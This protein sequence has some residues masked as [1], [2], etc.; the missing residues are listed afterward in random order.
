MDKLLERNLTIEKLNLSVR[1]YNCLKTANINTFSDLVFTTDKYLSNIKNMGVKSLEEINEVIDKL[2]SGEFDYE[3]VEND[4]VEIK[5]NKKLT[6]LDIIKDNDKVVSDISYIDKY[7]GFTNDLEIEELDLSVRS[8]NAIVKNGYKSTAQLINLKIK[9]FNSLRNL[10]VKSKQEIIERLKEVVIITYNEKSESNLA[11]YQDILNEIMDDFQLSLV[12]Y[13][14]A[15]LQKRL[16]L[17]IQTAM[18]GKGEIIKTEELLGDDEFLFS[19]YQ[20]EFLTSLIQNHIK[21]FIDDIKGQATLIDIS[22]SL[23]NHLLNS[24]LIDNILINMLKEKII[25]EKEGY[26]RRYYP[27]LTD[28]LENL[29]DKRESIVLINRLNGKTLEEIGNE[30]SVTRERVR[31][32]EKKAFKKIP[33]VREDDY[34]ESFEIYN[35]DEELFKCTWKESLFVY[36][37]L[38]S[39]Y[40]K[41]NVNI[42]EMLED[43][44]IPVKVRLRSENYI[45]KDYLSIGNSRIKKERQEILEYVIRIY[46]KDEVT[47]EELA[48]LYEMFLEDNKLVG[49]VNLQFTIRYFEAAVCRSK[50]VLWKFKRKLR[51]YDISEMTDEKIVESLN[52]NQLDNVEYSTLKLFNDYVEVMNEWDI[53]DEYE[54]HNLMKKVLGNSDLID[55]KFLRMPNIEFGKADRDIQVLELLLQTAPI[56]NA[57]LAKNYENE[58]GVK[59]ETV[60]A[61]YFKGIDEYCHNSIY[62]IDADTLVGDEFSIM[63]DK[64]DKDVYCIKDIKSIYI[65]CFPKGDSTLISPYNLK[66]LGFKI[67]SKLI[68]SD[69]Y[70]TLDDYFKNTILKDEIYDGNLLESHILTS[71]TYYSVIQQLKERFEIVEFLPNIFINIKRLVNKGI[72]KENLID[73]SNYV[74]DFVGDEI[75]TIKYLKNRGMEHSLDELGFDEWFYSSLIR[76][77]SRFKF[78]RVSGNVMFRKGN[79]IVSINNLI[80]QI[81]SEYRKIDIYDLIEV[82]NKEYGIKI[83]KY[84]ISNAAKEKELYYDTIMEKIYIDYDEYFE[85]V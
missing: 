17:N 60:L 45:F 68:Y 20:D 74:D 44:N 59:A 2:R 80:E 19:I 50:K 77:D 34:K 31:Q 55:I 69:K 51:Y 7:R 38:I 21:K 61:N 14:I 39:K 64:L 52:L 65:R 25:E 26:Y 67:T 66:R 12:E 82:I 63:K 29:N 33:R 43:V 5:L 1:T 8:Y 49:I 73:F 6:I 78:R 76:I 27:N 22:K 83:E 40:E 16:L 35:W 72:Y 56:L 3:L 41:G 81:V 62:S 4:Y 79:N 85:E 24:S 57:D 9:D 47:I 11:V 48:E 28:C 13:N 84:Q 10:G 75:F 70:S 54:L 30:L 42:E 32:I 46:C 71:Q 23:P 58:Y 37:Y 36:N 18:K 53:R 15:I